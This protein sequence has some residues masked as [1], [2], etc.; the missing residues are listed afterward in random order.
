VRYLGTAQGHRV[1]V[2][3]ARTIADDMEAWL[4]AGAADGFNLL[5]PFFPAPLD[6]FVNLVVPE[7]QAR[8]I[9]RT[10]YEG[11]T[12]RENLGVPTPRNRYAAAR[13]L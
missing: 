10:E 7:L 6:D 11:R 2:G 1:V 12:L 3:S 4:L 13:N 8:G 5:F 9:F